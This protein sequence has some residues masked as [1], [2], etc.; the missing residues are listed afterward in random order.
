MYKPNQMKILKEIKETALLMVEEL[1][2]VDF[3]TEYPF[4]PKEVLH[5]KLETEMQKKWDNYSETFMLD[6]TEFGQLCEMIVKEEV[7]ISVTE[8]LMKG[9][10]NMSVNTNGEIVY[11][12]NRYFDKNEL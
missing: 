9:E 8:L 11:S 7:S 5:T 10:M 3:F 4:I 2:S 6:E 1:D 12:S